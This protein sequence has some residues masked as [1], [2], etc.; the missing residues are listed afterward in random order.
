MLR[1]S[2]FGLRLDLTG[3]ASARQLKQATTALRHDSSKQGM[4]LNADEVWKPFRKLR[5]SL[6]K[7]GKRPTPD[8]VHELR[9]RTRQVEA[10]LH[11]LLLDNTGKGKKTLKAVNPIRKSAGPV[12]DMDVLSELASGLETDPCRLRLLEYLRQQRLQGAVKLHK[13]SLQKQKNAQRYLKR[14]STTL[15]GKSEG[16]RSRE[17]PAG[18]AAVALQLSG[19]L[20]RWPRLSAQNLHDFRKLAKQLRYVLRFSGEQT[21]LVDRL[22]EVKDAVG[23]WHDWLELD[24]IAQRLLQHSGTC[25]VK[26]EIRSHA[27]RN[28]DRA[29]HAA[30][31]LRSQYFPAGNKQPQ[32]RRKAARSVLEAASKLA[33]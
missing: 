8:E 31:L 27:R 14:F 33:A 20:Q 32:G 13:K 21:Q 12:R 18:A 4:P 23:L 11:A 15:K 19:Q 24:Q 29:L 9:T 28:F 16:G 10:S 2:L 3:T 1:G 6:R 25:A 30:N 7:L 26:E 22:G 17:W 5:K